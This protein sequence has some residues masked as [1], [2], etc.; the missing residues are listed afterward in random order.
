MEFDSDGRITQL[1]QELDVC[2]NQRS[3]HCTP[4]G[5]YVPVL[6]SLRIAW[7]L[8]PPG[9]D[10]ASFTSYRHCTPTVCHGGA[11]PHT[12]LRSLLSKAHRRFQAHSRS[13]YQAL[14]CSD[15]RWDLHLTWKLTSPL[16]LNLAHW[17]IDH[18][19]AVDG[20]H[21]SI[22]TSSADDRRGDA[23]LVGNR[24]DRLYIA[25]QRGDH[26]SRW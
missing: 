11:Q 14:F 4:A 23:L 26:E 24:P 1:R 20:N 6:A 3:R 22:A 2:R 7:T 5:C 25:V 9:C 16:P 21:E 15:Y 8:H 18:A 12:G 13:A 10:V 17:S 19:F